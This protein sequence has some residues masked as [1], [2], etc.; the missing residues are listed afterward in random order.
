MPCS[1]RRRFVVVHESIILDLRRDYHFYH[2]EPSKGSLAVACAR[3]V[4]PA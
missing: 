1:P 4:E 3:I 2:H